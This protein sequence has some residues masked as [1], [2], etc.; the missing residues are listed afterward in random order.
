MAILT[1]SVTPFVHAFEG[2]EMEDFLVEDTFSNVGSHVSHVED[3]EQ[4]TILV[5]GYTGVGT[6]YAY[7]DL[8]FTYIKELYDIGSFNDYAHIRIYYKVSQSGMTYGTFNITAQRIIEDWDVS[9]LTGLNKPSVSSTQTITT[10]E[11]VEAWDT[12]EFAYIDIQEDLLTACVNAS[13]TEVFYGYRLACEE[14]PADAGNYYYIVIDSIEAGTFEPV[15]IYGNNEQGSSES[16]SAD[17]NVTQIT[18]F[19]S[20]ALVI[21]FPALA[22]GG[23]L[24]S[25]KQT[26]PLAPMGFVTGLV[27]GVVMGV[28]VGIVPSW[29]VIFVGMGVIL[30]LWGSTKL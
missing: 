24:A 22:L 29:A 21:F 15:I 28:I 27:I 6:C 20:I 9:T 7:F 12:K 13:G 26:A 4:P 14:Y 19:L 17:D 1:I 11:K 23:S 3:T 8:N 10:I 16:S 25:S 30:L 2:V 18:E 5:S